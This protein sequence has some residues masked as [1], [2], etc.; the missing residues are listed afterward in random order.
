M[1]N[2]NIISKNRQ[3][4]F[5][6]LSLSCEILIQPELI[7]YFLPVLFYVRKHQAGNTFPQIR[8]EINFFERPVFIFIPQVISLNLCFR[9]EYALLQNILAEFTPDRRIKGGF[10]PENEEA[11]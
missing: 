11:H 6:V 4:Y 9:K 8:S 2:R 3:K 7:V 1:G 10:Y 5:P